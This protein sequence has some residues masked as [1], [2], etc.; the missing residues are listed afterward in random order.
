MFRSASLVTGPFC[1][2][3]I[4]SNSM[5][6]SLQAKLESRASLAGALNCGNTS[7]LALEAQVTVVLGAG[8][9]GGGAR[10]RVTE[11]RGVSYGFQLETGKIR[12]RGFAGGG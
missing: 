11:A 7:G 6:N 8:G 9:L 10:E 1:A 4:L 2:M 5:S 3:T 12:A